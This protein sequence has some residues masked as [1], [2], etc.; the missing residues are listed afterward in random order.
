[1]S[2]SARRRLMRDFKVRVNTTTLLWG[3][4]NVSTVSMNW[5]IWNSFCVFRVPHIYFLD[6]FPVF[7][8]QDDSPPLTF[9]TRSACKPILQPASLHLQLLIMS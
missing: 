9:H 3:Y 7:Y 4:L 6:S 5:L 8:V 1:M 2:T